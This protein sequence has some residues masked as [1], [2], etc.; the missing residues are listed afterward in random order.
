M[1]T[2]V[3]LA[4]EINACQ[5]ILVPGKDLHVALSVWACE[6]IAPLNVC[7]WIYRMYHQCIVTG[8]FV[9]CTKFLVTYHN[10]LQ[11]VCVLIV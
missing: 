3:R 9:L 2:T 7:V 5:G 4:C 10:L 6:H 1:K 11:L 8:E